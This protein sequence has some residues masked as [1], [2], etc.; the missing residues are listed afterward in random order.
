MKTLRT[1]VAIIGAGPAGLAAAFHL[2]RLGHQCVLLDEQPGPGGGLRQSGAP[3]WALEA[4]VAFLGGLGVRFQLGQAVR[5]P[6]ELEG[7]RAR[8]DAVVLATGSPERLAA[9][10][11]E[12][13]CPG[14]FAVGNASRERPS[15]IAVQAAADGRRLAGSVGLFLAGAPPALARRRFDSRL[16]TPAVEELAAASQRALRR[17]ARAS[18]PAEARRCLQCDCVRKVSCRLRELG[19]RLEADA[20]RFPGDRP[21]PDGPRVLGGGVSFEPGKCIRCGICVRIAERGHDRPGLGFSG[22][23]F[24]LRVK[25]P[26]NDDIGAAL[27]ATQRECVRRCPTGALAWER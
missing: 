18:A 14:V 9:L 3:P 27:P 1:Q 23:G 7:L 13:G 4:D 6:A 17:P 26:F 11:P 2:A 25:V 19:D 10:Q 21:R 24:D 5:A 15:R 20:R 12:G 22:R 16:G 8:H